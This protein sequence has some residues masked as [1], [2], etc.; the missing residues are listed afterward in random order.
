MK[1][2]LIDADVV[3]D[4]FL[5]RKPFSDDSNQI[6]QLCE[7]KTVNGFITPVIISNIYYILRK[8]A[9]DREIRI[10][11]KNLLSLVSIL[12]I[13][14]SILLK[15]LDS[16]FKDFEDAIQNFSAEG[17]SEIEMIVTR[18]TKDFKKSNLS[19]LTPAEFLKLI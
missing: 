4:F 19:I 17:S 3:L 15:A 10:Q 5:D 16:H 14:K 12:E 1:N 13:N 18:N 6:L 8:I 2:I 9:S 11:L 7:S